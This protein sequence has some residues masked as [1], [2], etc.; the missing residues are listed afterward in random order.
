MDA[1]QQG[2]P[3]GRQPA[4]MPCTST[5]IRACELKRTQGFPGA[6]AAPSQLEPRHVPLIG[7]FRAAGSEAG[8]GAMYRGIFATATSSSVHPSSS[9]AHAASGRVE[10]GSTHAVA[11]PGLRMAA[12]THAGT[13]AQVRTDAVSAEVDAAALSRQPQAHAAAHSAQDDA[14]HAPAVQ[15]RPAQA[16]QRQ[17]GGLGGPSA[18][19]ERSASASR[20]AAFQSCSGEVQGVGPGCSGRVLPSLVPQNVLITQVQGLRACLCSG[21]E[22]CALRL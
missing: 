11:L 3:S 14:A 15:E 10:R 20:W 1:L 17:G 18:A 12:S 8:T 5:R 13:S 6:Y 9:E 22:R 4:Q 7:Q 19:G 16:G 2:M 21:R